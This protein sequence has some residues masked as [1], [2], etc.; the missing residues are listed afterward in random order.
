MI[1]GVEEFVQGREVIF[2]CF[3]GLVVFFGIRLLFPFLKRLKR[4]HWSFV[5]KSKSRT[6]KIRAQEDLDFFQRSL[7]K[8]AKGASVS[9][10]R[11]NA[12]LIELETIAHRAR[13]EK[14]EVITK[15][16]SQAVKD[17]EVDNSDMLSTASCSRDE[18]DRFYGDLQRDITER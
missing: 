15:A 2:I 1:Q 10:Y 5:V 7:M 4:L 3:G 18:I 8:S 9:E 6:E 12:L 17:S 13:V 11:N 16:W 14:I